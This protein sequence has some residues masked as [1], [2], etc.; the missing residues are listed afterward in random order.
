MGIGGRHAAQVREREFGIEREELAHR[1]PACVEMRAL[2]QLGE[3][4]CGVG[5][6]HRPQQREHQLG[7]RTR[8]VGA[9]G[10]DPFEGVGII[11]RHQGRRADGGDRLQVDDV[12]HGMIDDEAV[13]APVEDQGLPILDPAALDEAAASA[14]ISPEAGVNPAR[15]VEGDDRAAG[16]EEAVERALAGEGD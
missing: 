14:R 2:H 3:Q 15:L 11:F 1:L 7:A 16:F 8:F 9:A 4:W 12:R 5:P 13:A 10:A 6:F